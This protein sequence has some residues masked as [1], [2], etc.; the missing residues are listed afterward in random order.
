MRFATIK[1]I[2]VLL[3]VK[4]STLYSWVHNGTIPFHKLNGLVRF[5]L[6]EIETWVKTLKQDTRFPD[7]APNKTIS[8]GID[9][10]IKNAIDSAKGKG[11]NS[12]NGK[13][14]QMQGLSKEV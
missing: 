12:S 3:S 9:K 13:P 2:S 7:I 4:A 1:E 8:H 6:D 11:Y 5:D 10:I 14:G